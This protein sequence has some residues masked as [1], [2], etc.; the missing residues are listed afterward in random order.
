MLCRR[1]FFEISPSGLFLIHSWVLPVRRQLNLGVTEGIVMDS[2]R[3]VIS[4]ARATMTSTAASS[5]GYRWAA[6]VAAGRHQVH[7]AMEGFSTQ[8]MAQV[9]AL[10]TR[11]IRVDANLESR[12]ARNVVEATAQRV[13]SA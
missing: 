12:W 1:V 7:F 9:R 8:G 11:M 10:P 6:K 2:Q 5:S 3:A 4:D 13:Q